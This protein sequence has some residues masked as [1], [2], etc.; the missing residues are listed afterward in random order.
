MLA[1][2]NTCLVGCPEQM[3]RN[4]TLF[5]SHPADTSCKIDSVKS[6]SVERVV[7]SVLTVTGKDWG[8]KK[9]NFKYLCPYFQAVL[10]FGY[11]CCVFIL[12]VKN[13][14]SIFSAAILS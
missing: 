3:K 11:K 2:S 9:S 6:T 13:N 1:E 8:A 14:I 4:I 7:F 5:K 10:I 12:T